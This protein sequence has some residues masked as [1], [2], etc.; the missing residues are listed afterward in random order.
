[1]MFPIW[2]F[3]GSV[4]LILGLFNKQM[5]RL[6]GLKPMSEV[7]SMPSLRSSSRRVEQ[8]GRWL[9][10]ALGMA[11]L[12]HGL[13][14]TLPE[15]VDSAISSLFVGASALLLVAMF[16]IAIANGKAQ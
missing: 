1:M 13:G 4:L 15:R 10:I 6:M 16:V 7:F 3:L 12:V 11:F 9:V 5:L 8:I 2:L 14:N